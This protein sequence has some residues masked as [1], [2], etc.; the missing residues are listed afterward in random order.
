MAL[1]LVVQTELIAFK[2]KDPRPDGRGSFLFWGS[3]LGLLVVAGELGEFVSRVFE[4][5]FA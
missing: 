5:F 2:I 1:V 3:C 4:G